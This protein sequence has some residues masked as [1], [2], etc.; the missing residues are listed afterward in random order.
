MGA[1]DGRWSFPWSYQRCCN[2]QQHGLSCFLLQARGTFLCSAPSEKSVHAAWKNRQFLLDTPGCRRFCFG[3]GR[4]D[5][6]R[7]I[8]RCS[9][10]YWKAHRFGGK[11]V[12]CM[13]QQKPEQ[14]RRLQGHVTASQQLIRETQNSR[15]FVLKRWG[16]LLLL[17]Q[18][19]PVSISPGPRQPVQIAVKG[20][21]KAKRR[22]LVPRLQPWGVS[23]G[24]CRSLSCI[25][26]HARTNA[27][28]DQTLL[29]T[30]QAASWAL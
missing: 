14:T 23:T 20:R 18:H 11:R 19:G 27:H 17:P 4:Q 8:S 28:R 30:H 9:V 13:I 24:V 10:L 3:T 7:H 2:P 25:S 16:A 29:K 6:T 22:C 15:I 5:Q 26:P 1:L 12:R 21:D